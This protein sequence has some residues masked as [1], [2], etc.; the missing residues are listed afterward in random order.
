LKITEL[1]GKQVHKG[2]TWKVVTFRKKHHPGT[3]LL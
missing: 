1:H 2:R 3:Y